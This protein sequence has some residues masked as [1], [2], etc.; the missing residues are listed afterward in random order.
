MSTVALL[1]GARV[2]GETMNLVDHVEERFSEGVPRPPAGVPATR[3]EGSPC[4]L[5]QRARVTLGI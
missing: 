1:Q 4:E 3:L 2:S 5:V